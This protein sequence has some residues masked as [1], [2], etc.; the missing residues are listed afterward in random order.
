[1]VTVAVSCSKSSSVYLRL[2]LMRTIIIWVLVAT[3]L[4][5]LLTF[6]TWILWLYGVDGGV[7][8][9]GVKGAECTYKVVW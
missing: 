7:C 5:L 2:V 6:D 3:F 1:M 9:E 4:I 8:P